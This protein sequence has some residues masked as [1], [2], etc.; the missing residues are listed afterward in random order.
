MIETKSHPRSGSLKLMSISRKEL[1]KPAATPTATP[2]TY[3]AF[4][5]G[6]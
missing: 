3:K 4:L 2:I 5:G 1:A 6:V